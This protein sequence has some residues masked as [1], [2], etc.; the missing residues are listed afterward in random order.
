MRQKA[1][2]LVFPLLVLLPAGLL[3]SA[4]AITKG[5][6]QAAHVLNRIAFGPRPGDV[7]RVQRMGIRQYIEQQLH[8]EKIDDSRTEERLRDFIS[9]R[10]DISDVLKRY[11][12]PQQI[13]RQLGLRNPQQPNQNQNQNS[14]QT[15]Q[16]AIRQKVQAYLRQNGL[17]PPQQLLQELIGQKIVRA[18][19]SDRQLQEVMTDFW[20]NHFN[21]F[22]G[23]GAD[24]WLTT[25]YEMNAIRP[26]AL[27]KFKDLLMATAK[28]PAMLF[29]LDNHLST[30][31]GP[32]VGAFV[33]QR[34]NGNRRA[35]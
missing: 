22:F 7:E 23:K 4:P 3:R 11:P 33:R 1:W 21:V 24:R 14:D 2:H 26:N 28:S 17:Q 9:L 8:P 35:G 31:P 6:D 30:A 15:S 12:E 32:L 10:M 16:A 25:S 34:G 5:Q 27:G 18:V 13:A 19:D 20:F 29:Y